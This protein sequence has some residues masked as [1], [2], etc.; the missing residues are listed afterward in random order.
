MYIDVVPNRN[1]PPAILLRETFREDGKVRKRT[2]ANLSGFTKAQ[3]A[4]L[5]LLLKGQPLAPVDALFSVVASRHHGHADAIVRAM[6]R[7]KLDK[8]LGAKR[9]RER[10]LVMAMIA[11]RILA[12]ILGLFGKVGALC[13]RLT[14]SFRRS[15][16]FSAP[17]FLATRA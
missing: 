10:Q 17:F 3:V 12:T 2:I 7:L 15:E 6:K 8:V 5:R 9:C 4:S 16:R 1:S 14:A 11:A 13:S